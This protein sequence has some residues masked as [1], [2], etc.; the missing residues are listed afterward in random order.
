MTTHNTIQ[1]YINKGTYTYNV[2]PPTKRNRPIHPKKIFGHGR[3]R[4]LMKEAAEM[5]SRRTRKKKVDLFCCFGVDAKT[6]KAIASDIANDVRQL[7]VTGAQ[8]SGKSNALSFALL[9]MLW[10]NQLDTVDF[11]LFDIKKELSFFSE[12]CNV[13][14]TIEGIKSGIEN[15]KER[16]YK[17]Y[18]NLNKAGFRNIKEYNDYAR[19]KR[20]TPM[21]RHVIV[22]DEYATTSF[23]IEG[24]NKYVTEL[25]NTGR[26]AGFYII[27]STQRADKESI[28]P[29]IKANMTC[30]L[31]FKSRDEVNAKVS[32][33]ERSKDITEVGIA[34]TDI[35]H[36]VD[37][38]RF[39]EMGLQRLKIALKNIK[40]RLL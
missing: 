34:A 35:R 27:A 22:I 8:G 19:K 4:Y 13:E 21:K 40:E 25:C 33:L 28:S 7:L 37:F 38:V 36:D 39:P 23:E 11:H 15:L 2:C 31:A 24:L 10:G 32:G 6:Q 1:N 18:K 17:Q 16:M 26:A 3:L 29:K 30:N 5:A 14:D 12:V 9:S 20:K